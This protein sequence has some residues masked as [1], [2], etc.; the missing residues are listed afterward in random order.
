MLIRKKT[1]ADIINLSKSVGEESGSNVTGSRLV[2]HKGCPNAKV[3][4]VNNMLPDFCRYCTFFFLKHNNINAK[5]H[6]NISALHLN[7]K[8]VSMFNEKFVNLLYTADLEN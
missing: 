3:R 4:N 2:P 6:C 8:G 1:A 7:S 5:A